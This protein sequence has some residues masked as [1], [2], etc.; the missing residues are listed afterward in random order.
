MPLVTCE[1]CG[2]VLEYS[3]FEGSSPCRA[4]DANADRLTPVGDRR[5]DDSW[6]GDVDSGN[7]GRDGDED[8]AAARG[9]MV[10]VAEDDDAFRNTI[11][12][13]S[14]VDDCWDVQAVR[15]GRAALESVDEDVDVLVADRRMP[16]LSGP[17]LVDRLD[18]TAFDGDV[19]IVSAYEADADLNETD[20][21]G[22]VT[23]PL[24]RRAYVDALEWIV[25][26]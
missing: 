23:K 3:I 9:Y 2:T 25:T 19:L 26:T 7:R 14:A 24:S 4:C 16:E 12:R 18:E 20:V 10:L 5:D 17:E 1:D 11:C 15:T 8:S 13:W 6:G 22:Y 21:D